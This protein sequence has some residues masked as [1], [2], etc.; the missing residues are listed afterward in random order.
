VGTFNVYLI[1]NSLEHTVSLV[2]VCLACNFVFQQHLLLFLL[3]LVTRSVGI[4]R[5]RTK[6]TELVIVSDGDGSVRVCTAP[7]PDDPLREATLGLR[8]NVEFG[9]ASY[10]CACP[11]NCLT[12]SSL[13]KGDRSSLSA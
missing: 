13:L 2:P 1:R 5:S 4:V 7:R 10:D 8:H 3:L 9:E 12:V 6:A 11:W